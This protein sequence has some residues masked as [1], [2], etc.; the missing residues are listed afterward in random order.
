MRA[1]LTYPPSPIIPTTAARTRPLSPPPPSIHQSRLS[2]HRH[3]CLFLAL[4]L[5]APLRCC[6][7]HRPDAP[8]RTL[9]QRQPQR[10]EMQLH[11]S[12]IV[13]IMSDQ[14]IQVPPPRSR[15]RPPSSGIRKVRLPLPPAPLLAMHAACGERRR[16]EIERTSPSNVWT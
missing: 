16:T 9:P 7:Y 2:C 4:F 11:Q 3:S 5:P 6:L 8:L 13:T 10:P 15:P 1:R 12:K 14:S